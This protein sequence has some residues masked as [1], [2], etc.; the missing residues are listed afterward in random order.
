MLI[1]PAGQ[2]GKKQVHVLCEF[3]KRRIIVAVPPPPL[4]WGRGAG[5]AT[6]GH[7]N[8]WTGCFLCRDVNNSA[9][10]NKQVTS[11]LIK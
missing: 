9:K 4:A 5:A 7:S 2:L 3:S 10:Y 11:Q 8:H 1:S 6:T